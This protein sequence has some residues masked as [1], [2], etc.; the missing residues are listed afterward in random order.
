MAEVFIARRAGPQG[1]GKRV[2]LKRI[3]PHLASDSRFVAM[4][5]DE[6]RICAA[7]THPNIVRVLDIGE[8]AGELY[9]ALEFVEGIS[10]A[11]LLRTVAARNDRFPLGAA[12]FITY[13]VLKALAYAHEATDENGRPLGIVHR[14]V[15]PGNILIGRGGDIKLT[16]FGIVRSRAIMRRTHPGELKGK[17]GYMSPEQVI[18][19]EVDARSDLFTVG[20]ILAE[21]LLL[22]P[23]FAGDNEF[24]ML[25]RMYEADLSALDRHADRLTPEI[26]ELL[27]RALAR[28]RDYRFQSA[29]EFAHAVGMIARNAGIELS[30]AALVPWLFELQLMSSQSGLHEATLPGHGTPQQKTPPTPAAPKLVSI[31]TERGTTP[32]I[33]SLVDTLRRR[34]SMRYHVK[35][36][37]GRLL[38]PVSIPQLAELIVTGRIGPRTLL[39]EDPSGAFFPLSRIEQLNS[40]ARHPAYEFAQEID[41][42]YGWTIERHGLPRVLY[43]LAL[44]R[45]NG[46][47]VARDGRR[48]KRVMFVD[49]SPRY[50]ASTDR[51]ELLGAWLV[52]RGLIGQTALRYA[53]DRACNVGCRLGEA[54]LGVGAIRPA[55][56][57]RALNEQLEERF[58][59]LL[60]WRSGML[61]F[62]QG[63]KSGFAMLPGP[64]STLAAITRG[65][66]DYYSDAEI[67]ELLDG[68][69]DAS[70]ERTGALHSDLMGLTTGEQRALS[71]LADGRRLDELVLE[72]DRQDVPVA[73]TLR[74]ILVGV[75]AGVLKARPRGR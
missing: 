59:E 40:L 54:L 2:A 15:S 1:F 25:T 35:L 66:R 60:Q 23:L 27:K 44:R 64:R 74:T 39:C 19:H 38:G 62:G 3:L 55:Q 65:V 67:A 56:L 22:R 5:S 31:P 34:A 41:P 69:R 20:I 73:N 70:F 8:S 45:E 11:K 28:E 52:R 36:N 63:P 10:C 33:S 49:G 24:E 53:L 29:R 14:D 26:V 51:E 4:F 7:L 72:L 75:S 37:K 16:D 21:M 50:L 61:Y 32:S 42:G 13:Q 6:A 9:M 57:L 68:W 46:I 47:L 18:G 30:D 43:N 17:L 71:K 48:Q 58:A 12:L